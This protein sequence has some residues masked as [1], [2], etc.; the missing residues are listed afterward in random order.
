MRK[1]SQLLSLALFAVAV[2][3]TQACDETEPVVLSPEIPSSLPSCLLCDSLVIP[4]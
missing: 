2:L 1:T 4:M 3:S